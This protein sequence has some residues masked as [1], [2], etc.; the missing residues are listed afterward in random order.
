MSVLTGSLA[1][2]LVNEQGLNVV[3]PDIYTSIEYVAFYERSLT[4]VEI[5]DGVTSIGD[6][7]FHG[8][9]LTSVEIGDS[10]ISI[11]NN[12]FYGNNL[13]SVEIPDSVTIIGGI[14]S[15][16]NQLINNAFHGNPHLESISI[17]EDS[18]FDSSLFPDGVEIIRRSGNTSP[19]DLEISASTFDE[20]ITA[21][22]TV[23]TLSSTDPDDGDTFTY[24][25]VS[26]E[27]A[28]DNNAFTI[29]GDELKIKSSPDYETQDSYSVRLRSTDSGGLTY[30][31]SFTLNVNDLEEES[32]Q[33]DITAP[34][35][36]KIYL[37]YDA[38]LIGF[39][40]K[41][42][43]SDELSGIKQVWGSIERPDGVVTTFGMDLNDETNEYEYFWQLDQYSSPGLWNFTRITT[44]DNANNYKSITDLSTIEVE[45]SLTI[46]DKEVSD[47]NAPSTDLS[48]SASTF[49]EN[50]TA[51]S[52]VANLSSTD[53]DTADTFTYSLISGTGDTDNNA[54]TIDGDQL[55]ITAS[56]DHETQ[57]SYSIRLKTTD[58]AGLSFEKA[59][60][61]AVNNIKETIEAATNKTLPSS[62]ENLV[63]TGSGNLKGYGNTSN[64]R[65]TGNS[66]N[67]V[68]DGKSGI[69][70]LI[71][72]G[73]NDT[74]IVDESKD[75][76]IEK[77]GG[78]TDTIRSSVNETLSANVE[79]LVLTGS[80][81]LKGYGN[82]G[83]NRLTGNSGDNVLE[84]KAGRDVLTGKDG[85]DKF[86]YRS[87]DDSG[88]TK[89][90]RDVITDFDG[91][92]SDVID[93]SKIDADTG[94]KGNQAFVYIGSDLFSG[95]QGEVR[96]ESSILGVNTGIGTT[97]DMQ[98]K[99][100]GVTDF[101]PDFLIL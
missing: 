37:E 95:T 57:D 48:V 13:T 11:G 66:G 72:K 35:V 39:N 77:A 31:K 12:A 42:I 47:N 30:K 2:A 97:A 6:N 60:T 54:F 52:A 65:L 84:G 7:A 21:A 44:E 101:S 64:N 46:P 76:V 40:I 96:F 59:F 14:A 83:K 90:T 34:T 8:N 88:I 91:T 67:N 24:S 15:H 89:L 17:S 22:S 81:N 9:N 92:E 33:F 53:P 94:A 36:S 38:E 5:G 55:K 56:P 29:D 63:L 75:R 51:G 62:I 50:I 27:G 23:A 98:I 78:G 68:L 86:I 16:S 18:T 80:E 43:V 41:A 28:T 71:G 73:G 93:L 26:G 58:A 49:D 4:S 25:L 70:T 3:I 10:V 20:N 19:T 79:N 69:D 99:L 32:K 82:S 1:A 74:Y 85:G 87:I 45:G 100:N 61:F